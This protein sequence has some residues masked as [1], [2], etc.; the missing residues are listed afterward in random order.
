MSWLR[1]RDKSYLLK[2]GLVFFMRLWRV[3]GL[4]RSRLSYR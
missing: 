4:K 1:L 2:G 3:F